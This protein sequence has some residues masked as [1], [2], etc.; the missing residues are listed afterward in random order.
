MSLPG[1]DSWLQPPDPPEATDDPGTACLRFY[2]ADERTD[3]WECD[4]RT[5]CPLCGGVVCAEHDDDTTKCDGYVVHLSCH[6][7]GCRSRECYED[8][9]DDDLLARAGL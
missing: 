4:E 5:E 9:R 1:Y 6:K 3:A 2:P 7:T 8:A